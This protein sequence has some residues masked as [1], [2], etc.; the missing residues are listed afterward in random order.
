MREANKSMEIEN[1]TKTN[2]YWKESQRLIQRTV[3]QWLHYF[4]DERILEKSHKEEFGQNLWQNLTKSIQ[5]N[6][7]N[8]N[9][10]A[11][12]MGGRYGGFSNFPVGYEAEMEKNSLI[13]DWE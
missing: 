2:E 8:S 6:G 9:T 5:K 7:E 3:D 4:K 11:S 13:E 1:Q 10:T 12:S